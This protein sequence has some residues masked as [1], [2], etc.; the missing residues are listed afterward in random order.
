[1]KPLTFFCSGETSFEGLCTD[2]HLFSFYRHRDGAP[3]SVR[4]K[5]TYLTCCILQHRSLVHTTQL[6]AMQ[7]V[8]FQ[9]HPSSSYKGTDIMRNTCPEKSILFSASVQ[10]WE[11]STEIAWLSAEGLNFTVTDLEQEKLFCPQSS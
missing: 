10:L 8:S 9:G 6:L 5:G 7:G 2:K 3:S 11:V 1:M 4:N